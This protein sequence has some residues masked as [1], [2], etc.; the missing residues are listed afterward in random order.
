MKNK[1]LWIFI[2]IIVLILVLN[3]IFG[4]S[5]YLSDM[6]NLRFLEEMVQENL[7]LAAAIYMV[8]TA[9][10]CVVLALPGVTFAIIAGLL[11]GPVLGTVFCSLAT[12]IG[13]M[14][15]FLAGRFFLKDSVKPMV[16]K[17]KYLK[18]WLFDES[19]TNEIFVLM[20]TRLVPLFP[21]NLQNFA[22]GITDIRFSTYSI[23][24]LFFMLP[25]TAIY[26]VGTAG[27]ADKENR[28]LYIGIAIVLAIAVMGIGA[29]LK[30]RYVQKGTLEDGKE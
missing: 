12:T 16:M 19:G 21:Y 25:G 23:C 6:D 26:T 30:K 22:Y 10:G 3:Y 14:F 7:M 9:V 2:G 28:I 8:L 29:F 17:N 15:A 11:F 13:A 24:S 20:I 5:S 18:K 27:L 4:W 1:K